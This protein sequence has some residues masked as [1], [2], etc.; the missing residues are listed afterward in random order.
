[1]GGLL[2]P[3]Q[4]ASPPPL[5]APVPRDDAEVQRVAAEERRRRRA[6]SGRSSTIKTSGQGVTEQA[7]VGHKRLL[8]E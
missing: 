2:S 4:K 5:P 8:G 6:Q 7:P 1:M 3:P